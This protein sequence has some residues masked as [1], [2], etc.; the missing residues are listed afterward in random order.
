MWFFFFIIYLDDGIQSLHAGISTDDARYKVSS[1]LAGSSSSKVG[2]KRDHYN[3]IECRFTMHI[4]TIRKGVEGKT[5]NFKGT[6]DVFQLLQTY[7]SISLNL[8][9]TC[10]GKETSFFF[11]S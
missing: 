4:L 5:R 10:I 9:V 1:I 2:P 8:K 11:F 7:C 6:R 3:S